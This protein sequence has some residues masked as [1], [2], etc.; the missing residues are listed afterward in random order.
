MLHF[1]ELHYWNMEAIIGKSPNTIEK[2]I[3]I[4]LCKNITAKKGYTTQTIRMQYS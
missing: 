2:E 3:N 4:D 1:N